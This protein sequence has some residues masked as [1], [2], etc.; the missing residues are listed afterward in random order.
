MGILLMMKEN[1]REKP[2]DGDVCGNLSWH[3][4]LAGELSTLFGGREKPE[5]VV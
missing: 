5:R 3:T 4:P 1:K 2:P